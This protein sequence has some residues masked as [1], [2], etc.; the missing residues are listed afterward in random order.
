LKVNGSRKE[1]RTSALG[2]I[3][4]PV[5]LAITTVAVAT[6]ARLTLSPLL[7]E[8]SP[9]LLNTVAILMCS[10]Y[11]GRAAGYLATI[12]GITAGTYFFTGPRYSLYIPPGDELARL[13]LFAA[14]GCA[15]SWFVGRT[16][17]LALALQHREEELSRAHERL[18]EV[19]E[20]TSDAIFTVN[21]DWRF[22]YLNGNAKE[23]LASGRDLLDVNLWEAFPGLEDS[24]FGHAF[25][26]AA[27]ERAPV[28][29]TAF[30]PA[31]NSWFEVRAYPAHSG[32]AVYFRNV[33]ARKKAEDARR[34]SEQRFRAL[35]EQ[36]SDGIF[37]TDS[38]GTFIT[39][40]A[41]ASSA[42]RALRFCRRTFSTSFRLR[43]MTTFVRISKNCCK[44]APWFPNGASSAGTD[45]LSR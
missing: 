41:A 29:T 2:D 5:L 8:K 6:I 27:N 12:L 38:N 7:D 3:A 13:L 45:P 31:L 11:S 15:I 28:Q 36:A 18:S 24:E 30:L 17:S 14:T 19:L 4:R 32:L 33:T 37:I 42:T 35:I 25:R 16:R 26:R 20:S 21:P 44:A 43:I 39:G 1:Q 40:Q 10:W 34:E 9:F 22:R 23:Q